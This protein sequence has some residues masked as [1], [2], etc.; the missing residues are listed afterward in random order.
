MRYQPFGPAAVSLY[1]VRAE[2]RPPMTAVE[3]RVKETNGKMED[4]ASS[5]VPETPPKKRTKIVDSA[6]QSLR[7]KVVTVDQ[8]ENGSPTKVRKKKKKKSAIPGEITV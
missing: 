3:S 6:D 7:N 2:K 5:M 1:P 8:V 4:R